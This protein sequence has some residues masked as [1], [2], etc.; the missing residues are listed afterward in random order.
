MRKTEKKKITQDR[1]EVVEFRCDLCGSL[2]DNP[3][4]ETWNDTSE[5]DKKGEFTT[6]E[7]QV[8]LKN[9]TYFPWSDD[10]DGYNIE[11]DLCPKCFRDILVPFL[12]SRGIVV[13]VTDI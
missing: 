3:K 13:I 5:I 12:E 11:V 1:E 9:R 8:S 6:S 2:A 4:V 10:V 7:M